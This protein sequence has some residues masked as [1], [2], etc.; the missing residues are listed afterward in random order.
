MSDENASCK[1]ALHEQKIQQDLNK[2]N[3]MYEKLN[4]LNTKCEDNMKR[5]NNMMLELK[6]I[7]AMVRPMAKKNDWYG[8]EVDAQID[9]INFP[10]F[11]NLQKELYREDTI[12]DGVI[13]AVKYP[14]LEKMN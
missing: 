7:I 6:G 12:K 13:V 4:D 14:L 5:L 10:P 2:I 3:Q 8:E 11:V 9:K 1:S